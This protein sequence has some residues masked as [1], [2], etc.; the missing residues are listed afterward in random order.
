MDIETNGVIDPE[1]GVRIAA[2]ILIDQ[3]SLFADLEGTANGADGGAGTSIFGA[4]NRPFLVAGRNYQIQATILIKK[5]TTGTVYLGFASS[6]AS[7]LTGALMCID[8]GATIAN[9]IVATSNTNLNFSSSTSFSNA[10]FYILNISGYISPNANTR[11][12]LNTSAI[13][14][15]TV[16]PQAGSFMTVT[17]LGTSAFIGNL[18]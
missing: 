8:S 14:A 7:A 10:G 5:T 1:E 13:G 11:I 9:V 15:G 18:G 17:D 6:V 16:Q 2:R 3:M 4:T 12:N